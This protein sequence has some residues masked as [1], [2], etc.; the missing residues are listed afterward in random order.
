M[1][2]IPGTTLGPYEVTAKIGQGAAYDRRDDS[3]TNQGGK[4]L[5]FLIVFA[6]A[7][8]GGLYTRRGLIRV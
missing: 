8:F 3:C 4:G 7:Q 1:L 2:L 6:P 5:D